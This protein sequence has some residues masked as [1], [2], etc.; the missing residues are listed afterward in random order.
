ML[1]KGRAA[2]QIY[3][4]KYIQNATHFAFLFVK[5]KK[6]SEVDSI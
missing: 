6:K 3:V 5:N 4:Q 1:G 2:T